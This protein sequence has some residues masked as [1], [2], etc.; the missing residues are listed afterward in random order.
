MGK[1]FAV[2]DRTIA[3]QLSAMKS[4]YPQFETGFT[5]HSGLKVTGALQPT[6]RSAAYNF[7]LKYN[8]TENPKIKI[9]SPELKKNEK[10]E[11]AEHLYPNGYLCLYQPKYREFTRTDLLTDTIIPWASLWLYHYEVW[12]LT[13]KWLGGGEH[14]KSKNK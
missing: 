4:K 2:R 1:K 12:H 11:D 9:V 10:G 8:L 7:V 3:E 13:G 5:S 14:P 6:S